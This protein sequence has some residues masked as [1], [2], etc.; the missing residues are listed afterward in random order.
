MVDETSLEVREGEEVEP[1][2]CSGSGSPPPTFYWTLRGDV[3]AE[4]ELLTFQQPLDRTEAGEY[5][6]HAANRQGER[7]ASLNISVLY[8]PQCQSSVLRP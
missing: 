6:C 5:F 7:L 4:G 1:I 3:V 8:R 2:L